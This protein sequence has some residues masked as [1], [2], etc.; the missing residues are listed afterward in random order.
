MAGVILFH[1]DPA[2][3]PGGYVGVDVFFV[4]SGYLITHQLVKK[5]DE[6]SFS[7]SEFYVRRLRRLFPATL[8]TI[9]LAGVAAHFLLGVTMA[10]DHFGASLYCITALGNV[11]FSQATSYFDAGAIERPLL[12]LWS[13][14]VEEQ[15]YLV[16]PA[17]LFGLS[18][19]PGASKGRAWPR[20][21]ALLLLGAASL[22]AAEY[23]LS[24]RPQQVFYL[25]HFR[26]WEFAVGAMV[27]ITPRPKSLDR[28]QL[29]LYLL[30]LLSIF[31]A[32][33]R[34][35]DDTRFPGF[36]QHYRARQQ[37]SLSMLRPPA[38]CA[39]WWRVALSSV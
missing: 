16:W 1:L 31:G 27:S 25:P 10:A 18:R 33:A 21:A 6:G 29:P 8:A 17:L 20:W 32:M 4:I 38:I 19:F 14:G 23:F 34:F 35:S 26:A 30:G 13:L 12:H 15:F 2:W 9:V 28:F 11:Y 39:R 3:V 36:R 5:L 22:G 7:F 24:T 37:R